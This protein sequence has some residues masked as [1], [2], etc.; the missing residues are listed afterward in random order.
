MEKLD[1]ED[2]KKD[3]QNDI[4]NDESLNKISNIEKQIEKVKEEVADDEN[5]D[6]KDEMKSFKEMNELLF[7]KKFKKGEH[8]KDV[9]KFWDTQPVTNFKE[10]TVKLG[11]IDDKNDL[12]AVRKEPL[13]L[14]KDFIWQDIDIKNKK[15]LTQVS[16]FFFYK[17]PKYIFL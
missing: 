2:N 6:V 3:I 8:I 1:K 13:A 14:P 17:L 10:E 7:N 16:K 15:E 9:Y 4:I 5:V 11:P 12:E